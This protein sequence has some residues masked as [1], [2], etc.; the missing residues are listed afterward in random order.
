MLGGGAPK[1]TWGTQAVFVTIGIFV[2][3]SVVAID[4]TGFTR[5]SIWI[6][7]K[8][9]ALLI[10]L[11]LVILVVAIR[12]PKAAEST[13]NLRV[14]WSDTRW[15]AAIGAAYVVVAHI[16]P[17]LSPFPDRAYWGQGDGASWWLT[18][19]ALFLI[20]AWALSIH[21]TLWRW[22]AAGFLLGAILCA[23]A[24]ITQSFNWTVDFTST[25]GALLPGRQDLLLSSIY[26]G[27]MPI[28]FTLHRGHVGIVLSLAGLVVIYLRALTKL[29]SLMSM[30]LLLPV[31][32]ALWL[33]GTRA[34]WMAFF[35]GAT[36]LVFVYLLPRAK[37]RLTAELCGLVLVSIVCAAFLV[38]AG[39]AR[40]REQP[41]LAAGTQRFTSG[42]I[43]L[44]R[45]AV[46]FIGQ[47]PL[48]GWGAGGFG[49]AYGTN[50]AWARDVPTALVTFSDY[51][52]HY[53]LAG[54]S[55]AV[56]LL[57][58]NKAHNIVLDMLLTYGICGL[59]CYCALWLALMWRVW[60]SAYRIWLGVF[61]A[62]LSFLLTWY[63]A[64]G[65]GQ[66][67]WLLGSVLVGLAILD[68]GKA[69]GPGSVAEVPTVTQQRV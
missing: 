44:W 14:F 5:I 52:A 33:T 39:D 47:R 16:T 4:P 17:A 32:T 11:L 68:K 48:L 55:D 25:S 65:F 23:G 1:Y 12:P 46:G 42:R 34:P 57:P 31:L 43:A 40:F 28:G 2:A 20:N 51:A 69:V 18:I 35:V 30:F 26:R 10:L 41:G 13:F 63:D 27:Q 66:L 60:N 67:P 53:P 36:Y 8:T 38:A 58:T 56:V 3:L 7:P 15:L 21:P 62:Y 37:Y 45:E 6:Q 9:Y 19:L 49:T 29:R 64:P 22:E 50:S 24:V 61:F 59:V 54:G